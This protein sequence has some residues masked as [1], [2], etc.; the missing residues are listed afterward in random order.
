MSNQQDVLLNAILAADVAVN[1]GLGVYAGNRQAVTSRG[2]GITF[3]TVR[4]LMGDAFEVAVQRFVKQH[5]PGNGDIALWGLHFPQWLSQQ[6]ELMPYPYVATMASL[7]WQIAALERAADA[8]PDGD[9]F[10]LLE[11]FSTDE[12]HIVLNPNC[13]FISSVFPIHD[14]WA[15]HQDNGDSQRLARIKTSLSDP[16]YLEYLLISRLHWKSAVFALTNN[17]FFLLQKCREGISI[18]SILYELEIMGVTFT[19]W[20]SRMLQVGVIFGFS[21]I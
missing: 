11:Q 12:L 21:K 20:F 4:I 10:K 18:A 8:F 5:P 15:Y 3:P 17:E 13:I 19:D 1:P 14:I 7:E 2:F 9:S 6:A 16:E